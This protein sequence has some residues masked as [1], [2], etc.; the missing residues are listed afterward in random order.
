M[1]AASVLS[2]AA[3]FLFMLSGV[4]L[5]DA[6]ERLGAAVQVM[7]AG[8][9]IQAAEMIFEPGK[10]VT[11]DIEKADGVRTRLS[12]TASPVAHAK[13]GRKT[14]FIKA[15]LFELRQ[16]QWTLVASPGLG[17]Y[18]GEAATISVSDGKAAAYELGFL[19]EALSEADVEKRL[20][21]AG[22]CESELVSSG[23]SEGSSSLDAAQER[24]PCCAARCRDG[25]NWTLI[26]CGASMCCACGVCCAT[27]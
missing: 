4:A 24:R 12:Y 26:C 23:M 1:S 9:E 14:V 20:A 2:R 5:A 11:L 3:L 21:D 17:V 15:E 18:L 27:E 7:H 8:V 25:S 6:P 16:G 19:A 13:D 22:K 10:E